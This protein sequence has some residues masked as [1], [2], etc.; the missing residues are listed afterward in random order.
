MVGADQSQMDL[1]P[2]DLVTIIVPLRLMAPEA[3]PYWL[4]VQT[5]TPPDNIVVWLASCQGNR[6]V[7]FL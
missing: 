3:P 4:D 2:L 6:L 1:S 5:L 7:H